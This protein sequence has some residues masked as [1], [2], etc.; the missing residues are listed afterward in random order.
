MDPERWEDEVLT[1]NSVQRGAVG[2]EV[3]GLCGDKYPVLLDIGKCLRQCILPV[4][5]V[6]D[7]KVH[8]Y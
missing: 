8:I 4:I 1:L 3:N 2:G 5:T 7:V 6:A